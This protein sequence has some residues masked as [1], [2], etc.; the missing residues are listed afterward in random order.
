MFCKVLR[1]DRLPVL[2]RTACL[3]PTIRWTSCRSRYGRDCLV[4]CIV[5][6]YTNGVYA[7]GAEFVL[8]GCVRAYP[9]NYH[10]SASPASAWTLTNARGNI[11][12]DL[13]AFQ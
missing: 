9:A 11:R 13:S 2:C 10:R 12:A 4:G 7:G 8:A 3:V 6:I 1:L 5:P